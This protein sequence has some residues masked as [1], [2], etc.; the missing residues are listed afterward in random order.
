MCDDELNINEVMKVLSCELEEVSVLS[1]Y[2]LTII[3]TCS[4][5]Q[6]I[7]GDSSF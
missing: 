4:Y 3:L 1:I 7:V 6:G 5:C 2:T